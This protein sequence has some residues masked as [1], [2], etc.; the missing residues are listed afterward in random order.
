MAFGRREKTAEWRHWIR[1][2]RAELD[3][4]GIPEQIAMS[5]RRWHVFLE[6]GWDQES[7]WDID[8]LTDDSADAFYDFLI[9]EYGSD[10]SW[11]SATFSPLEN[12]L[13][14][15]KALAK[16]LR[17]SFPEAAIEV[18]PRACGIPALLVR[19]GA[20]LLVLAY[21][22]EQAT[23]GVG[24]AEDGGGFDVANEFFSPNADE[25][26]DYLSALLKDGSTRKPNG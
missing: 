25:A 4:F 18:Q 10:R 7:G 15:I 6:H 26:G 13:G 23:F 17:F 1:E 14:R 12:R 2:H 3:R 9:H 21:V 8:W 22:P 19:D 5:E 11:F 24:E 20:R 16:R